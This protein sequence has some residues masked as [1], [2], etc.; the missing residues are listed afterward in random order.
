MQNDTRL[1]LLKASKDHNSRAND[2]WYSWITH[3][4][5]VLAAVLALLA[6]L[7]GDSHSLSCLSLCLLRALYAFS[8]ATLVVGAV[9]LRGQA[10]A[11][12]QARDKLKA[13]AGKQSPD[14]SGMIHDI[15]QASFVYNLCYVVYPWLFY[16][17]II[18][19]AAYGIARSI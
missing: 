19:L 17:C 9:A 15:S 18:A 1:L 5:T 8:A 16:V 12:A 4:M 11:H 14:V 6:G 3:T 10:Q 7:S 2:I 13:E